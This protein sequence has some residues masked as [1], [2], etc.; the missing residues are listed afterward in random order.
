M[1]QHDLDALIFGTGEFSFAPGATSAANA[2]QIGFTD[3]GNI[4]SVSI[5]PSVTK[6]E[7]KGSYRGIKRTDRTVVSES[8]LEYK[9]KC[10]ELSRDKFLFALLGTEGTNHSQAALTGVAGATL[11]FSDTPAVPDRW[12][13]LYSVTGGRVRNL[14]ALTI[15]GLVEKTD[16]FV[17]YKLGRVRFAEEQIEDVTP[18]IT[19]PAIA[20]ADGMKGI[21]PATN[22]IQKGYGRLTL[23][24]DANP[25][26]VVYDH[27]DFSCEVSFD[28]MGEI[29]GANFGSISLIVLVTDDAGTVYTAK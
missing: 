20:A 1:N 28:S 8:K 17:D 19:A 5:S 9:I 29:D 4:E 11:D 16:F 25:D 10:D 6:V 21:K 27:V 14:T 15:T 18:T 3:F 12:Y 23:F 24:D 2:K 13:D 7:H 26:K 22:S